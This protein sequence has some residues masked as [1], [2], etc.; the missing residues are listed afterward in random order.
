MQTAANLGYPAAI[1]FIAVAGAMGAI[2]LTT[3]LATPRPKYAKGTKSHEG[4][5]AIVG[6]GGRQEVVLMNGSAWL[7]PDKPTL[8]DIP[9]GAE[10]IPSIQKY[11]NLVNLTTLQPMSEKQMVISGYNDRNVIRSVESLAYLIRQ[12]TKQQRNITYHQEF[13]LFKAAKGL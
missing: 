7:T 12:Q 4:G 6:D 8:V 2:Q 3:I 5:L 13:E 9:K 11:D 1:P 10:V